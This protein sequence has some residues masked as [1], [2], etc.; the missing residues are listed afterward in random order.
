MGEKVTANPQKIV[1]GME[2]EVHASNYIANKLTT[3][4]H[5]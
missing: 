3:P 5:S 4:I 1:A 2:A